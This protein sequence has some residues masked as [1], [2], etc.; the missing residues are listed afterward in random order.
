MLPYPEPNIYDFD[1][2]EDRL[3]MD[4]LSDTFWNFWNQTA[5]VNTDAFEKVFHS[6]PTDKVRNWKQYDEYWSKHFAVPKG[7]R[8]VDG[9]EVG[10]KAPVEWGHV[11]K[12]EFSPGAAG[13][14]EVREVLYR[15]RGN[16]VEMPLGFLIGKWIPLK[17]EGEGR[18]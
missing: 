2:A 9:K 12:S 15:V 1:S 3:V 14:K 5:R 18:I 11:V 6:V 8:M 17:D 7:K 13:A 10:Q 4:P 16:L